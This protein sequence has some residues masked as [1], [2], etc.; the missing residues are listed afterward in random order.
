M[1]DKGLPPINTYPLFPEIIAIMR[2]FLSILPVTAKSWNPSSSTS[3]VTTG[4]EISVSEFPA[5][6]L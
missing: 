5:V 1:I 2:W 3:G 4:K 6:G